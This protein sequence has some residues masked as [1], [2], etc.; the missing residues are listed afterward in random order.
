[1]QKLPLEGIR[2]ADFTQARGGSHFTEWLGIMGAEVIKI[3]TKTR[4]DL[5]RIALVPGRP[6]LSEGLNQSNA[7]A[8]FNFGKKSINLNMTKPKAQELAKKLVKECDIVAD[9][10]GGPV[11]ERWGL[12]YSGLKELKPDVIAISLSGWGKA[13]PY[14]DR[15]A[16]APIID[17]FSG[18]L[19]A[20]GH[21]GSPPRI[22]GSIGWCDSVS[23]EYGVFAV[24]AALYHRSKT[25]E[26]QYIDI[27]M[28][29]ASIASAPEL[30]LNY[31]I[32]QKVM[33][34]VGNRDEIMAPHGCYRCKGDD[35]WVAIAVS[36]DAEWF[37]LC[38]VMGNPEW[39]RREEF[40]DALSRWK[41][42]DELDRLIGEWTVNYTHHEVMEML[43]GAGVMAGASIDIEE[44]ATD[45][46]LKARGVL[47]E[48][49]HPVM[50]KIVRIGMPFK[51]SESPRGN[52]LPAPLIG[53]HND[54]VFGELLGLPIDEIRQLEEEQV[55]Y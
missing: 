53:E 19:F 17:A 11:M 4:P 1:M 21:I 32:N 37:A 5:F 26:G 41:N 33:E 30:A 39:T 43:Q 24:M 20:N 42:Q 47:V 15:P 3:E 48:M 16:Y 51:L 18:F 28:I 40:S 44:M 31:T 10:F 45:P 7:F 12:G 27:S 2:V 38:D 9:N 6:D 29:E 14:P 22:V 35:K 54:Q 46:Q 23:A 52:Y 49:E 25:G 8:A 55:I 50:K 34:R 13:G 36:S